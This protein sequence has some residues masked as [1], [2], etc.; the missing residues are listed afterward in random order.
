M[1]LKSK[2]HLVTIYT[3]HHDR[4]HCFDETRD[5]SLEVRVRGDFI[6]RSLYGKFHVLFAIMK[7]LYLACFLVFKDYDVV[8]VDQL[9]APIPLLKLGSA[10]VHHH[11]FLLMAT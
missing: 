4:S 8:I 11:D 1:G 9:S 3:S 10:K 5:G 7:S 6:P 2:G